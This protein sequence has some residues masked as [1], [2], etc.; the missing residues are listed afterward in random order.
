MKRSK[1]FSHVNV[2]LFL[3]TIFFLSAC[4]SSKDSITPENDCQYANYP[5]CDNSDYILP[6]LSGKKFKVVQGNCSPQK[7]PWTHF[8]NMKY[9]YDF[10][11]PIGTEIVAS[12][13]GTVIFV[14]DEFTD[15]DHGADQGNAIVILHDNGTTA[16]YGHLTFKGSKVLLGQLVEQGQ[17]IALSGNSGQ[18]PFPHLHFQLNACGDF[19]NC[20]S[21]P[22]AFRNVYPREVI[23][24]KDKTYEAQ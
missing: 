7:A 11:M 21:I 18:S 20:P 5:S 1:L 15:N 22:I 23:L 14:R 24:K 6:F 3:S 4:S 10:A 12:Y 13:R 19:S 9:A 17:V 16:L 8:K 2:F